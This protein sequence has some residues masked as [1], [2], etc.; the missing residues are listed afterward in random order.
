MTGREKVASALSGEGARQLGVVLCYEGIY[1]RDHWSQLTD[2]PWWHQHAPEV[3]WQVA[4]RR[5]VLQR[6]GMDWFH[7]AQAC[8]REER[9][10]LSLEERADGVWRRDARSGRATRL[11]PPVV[12]G[13]S[14][15][16]GL[17]SVRPEHLARSPEEV[18]AAI[19]GPV[20]FSADDFRR[21]GRTDLVEALRLSL[22]DELYPLA[23]VPSPLWLCYHLWGF[24]GMMTQ[25][26]Q[27]PELV[28][29]ACRRYLDLHLPGVHQAAAL[30][31][32]GVWIEECLTDLVSPQAY[33]RLCLPY[34]RA[35][36]EETRACG[37]QSIYYYCGDPSDRFDL[38]VEAGADALSLE[39]SKKGFTIDIEDVLARVNGRCA[40]LGNLDAVGVLQ[41]DTEARLRQEVERQVR[42]GRRH[43]SRFVMGLGSPV[44]PGTPVARVRLYCDLARDLGR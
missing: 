41:D 6:T 29:R 10:A 33:R 14:P 15:G 28:A 21:A 8:S 13:W 43:G 9:R 38:L 27:E 26:A 4:W 32:A 2:A 11:C 37:M 40:V 34:L 19:P 42:A 1:V 5:D 36:V 22:G 23:S 31:A 25:V 7:V 39:E 44:T 3:D 16:G 35:V 17:H 20:P 12:G 18:D 30:G 24:E